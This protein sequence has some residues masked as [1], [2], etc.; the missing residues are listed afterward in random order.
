MR[1]RRHLVVGAF[2]FVLA[3]CSEGVGPTSG[4]TTTPLRVVNASPSQVAAYVDGV[5]VIPVVQVGSVSQPV[6]IIAGTVH[7]LRLQTTAGASTSIS[8]IGAGGRSV[9]AVA[10]PTASSGLAASVLA[11]TGSAVPASKSKLRVVHLSPNAGN[12]E[13]WRTQPD[14]QTPIHIMTPFNYGAESPFL[15]S[16]PGVWEVFVTAAG[17]TTKTASTGPITIPAGQRRTAI[18]LDSAGNKLWRVISD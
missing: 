16:D 15:Q 6:D 17:S 10:A 5:L 12:I 18:L 8:V 3:A 9:T 11:D 4:F 2:A 13:I 7:T 14:F 1:T